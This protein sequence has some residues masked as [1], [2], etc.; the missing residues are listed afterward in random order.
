MDSVK[1]IR[2]MSIVPGMDWKFAIPPP[3]D[4]SPCRE[5]LQSEPLPKGQYLVH[6]SVKPARTLGSRGFRA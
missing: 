1:V 3:A 6:N 4:P 5:G 2:V